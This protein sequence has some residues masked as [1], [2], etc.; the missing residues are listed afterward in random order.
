M[1]N[2]QTKGSTMDDLVYIEITPAQQTIILSVLPECP[3][4]DDRWT[5]HKHLMR[6]AVTYRGMI[7][8]AIT[9]A[10]RT[11][12]SFLASDFMER[13]STRSLNAWLTAEYAE[14]ESLTYALYVSCAE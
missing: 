12:I 4:T 9:P 14:L 13:L 2:R 11:V 10:E 1:L 6:E 5:L 7:M 3:S 8:C